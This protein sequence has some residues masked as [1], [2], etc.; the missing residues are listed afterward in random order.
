MSAGILE[1]EKPQPVVKDVAA[2]YLQE[3]GKPMPGPEH[4][5]CQLNLGSEFKK[6]KGFVALSELNLELEGRRTVPDICLYTQEEWNSIRH[7]TWVTLPPRIA[8]EIIS[9][10]QTIEEMTGKIND[11]LAA[12]VPSVWL[13]LPFARVITIFQKDAPLISATSGVLTDPAT[14]ISVNVD[15]VFG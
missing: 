10:S 6:S 15:E 7:Q 13:L 2:A 9:P 4:A 1:P 14:G 8:V 5:Y 12:G 3:R 11:L